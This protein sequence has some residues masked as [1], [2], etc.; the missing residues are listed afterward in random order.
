MNGTP[1]GSGIEGVIVRKILRDV[2]RG[3][4]EDK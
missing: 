3:D 2:Q 1:V 4:F